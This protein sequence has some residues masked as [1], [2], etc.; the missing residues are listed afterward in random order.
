MATIFYSLCGEGRG[1]ALR[2]AHTVAAHT[3]MV[4]T[5]GQAYDLLAPLYRDTEVQV[6]PIDGMCFQYR[7]GQ[8]DYTTTPMRAASYIWRMPRRIDRL[9]HGIECDQPGLVVTDFDPLL[10]RAATRMGVPFISLDHQHFLLAYDLSSLG[11]PVPAAGPGARS[12]RARSIPDTRCGG[13]SLPRRRCCRPV[14]AGAGGSPRRTAPG[15]ATCRQRARRSP[16]TRG[17]LWSPH[18]VAVATPGI[19]DAVANR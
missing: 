10:P 17:V 9:C 2:A 7:G 1:H 3:V 5:C 18:A 11:V 13:P 19:R 15:L 12:C 6:R 8:V 16:E 4:Y 14:P